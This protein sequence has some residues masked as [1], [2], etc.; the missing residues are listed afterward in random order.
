MSNLIER[1]RYQAGCKDPD[2]HKADV[3][4]LW[5]AADWIE[6]L[7]NSVRNGDT[8]MARDEKRIK[9]LEADYTNLLKRDTANLQKLIELKRNYESLVKWNM[10][11]SPYIFGGDESY[12]KYRAELRALLEEQADE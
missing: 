11:I 9:E 7:E 4:L 2:L 1:L 10:K 8:L 12:Q 5:E 3:D 6:E